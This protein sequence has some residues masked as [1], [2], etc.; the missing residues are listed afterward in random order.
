MFDRIKQIWRQWSRLKKGVV[1]FSTLFIFYT[2]IGFLVLPFIVKDQIQKKGTDVLARQVEVEDVFINPYLFRARL[3]GFKVHGK[4]NDQIVMSFASLSG[5]VHWLPL[6]FSQTLKFSTI[7]LQEPVFRL[8]RY[9]DGLLNISDFLE[10]KA[11]EKPAEEMT[12]ASKNF[13]NLAMSDVSVIDGAIFID[14]QLKSFTHKITA[15]NFGLPSIT[16]HKDKVEDVVTPHFSAIVNGTLFDFAGESKPFAGSHETGVDFTCK[17]MDLAVLNPYLPD[18]VPF[19]LS[20]GEL[21]FSLRAKS[22]YVP[23]EKRLDLSLHGDIRLH[24][25]LIDD[26][27]GVRVAAVSS[28]DISIDTADLFTQSLRLNSIKIAQPELYVERLKDGTMKFADFLATEEKEEPEP[29]SS[30]MLA[31]CEEISI[32]GGTLV[33]VDHVPAQVTTHTVSELDVTVQK[34]ST[35]PGSLF[36]FDLGLLGNE[37]GT[38]KLAGQV[39]IFPLQVQVE[40]ELGKF[41]LASGQNYIAEQAVVVLTEGTASS[42]FAVTG[43]MVEQGLDFQLTADMRIDDLVV[44]AGKGKSEVVGLKSFQTGVVVKNNPFSLKVKNVDLDNPRAYVELQKNGALNMA[45]LM[46][47]KQDV[48]EPAEPVAHESASILGKDGKVELGLL[49]IRNGELFVKDRSIA[50]FYH[51]DITD[52][53]GTVTDVSTLVVEGG[54]FTFK[55]LFDHHS[56]FVMA[57]HANP[58]PPNQLLDVDMNFVDIEMSPFSPYSQKFIGRDLVKGKLSLKQ[59]IKVQ[60][61]ALNVDTNIYLDQLGL[62]TYK[63]NDT[64]TGLPVGLAVALLQDRHG[65][66]SFDVPIEGSLDDPEFGVGGAVVSVLVNLVTKAAMSPFSLLGSMFSGDG[67][68]QFVTFAPETVSVDAK[69][70]EILISFAKVLYDRPGLKVEIASQYD[71]VSEQS[72]VLQSKFMNILQSEKLQDVKDAASGSLDIVIGTEEFGI[73]L[74][75]AYKTAEFKRP[76]NMVGILEKQTPAEMERMLKA[77]IEVTP[78]ELRLLAMQRGEAV[79]ALLR[80]HGPVESERLFVLEPTLLKIG[81][82]QVE[83]RLQ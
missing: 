52:I 27:Q 31:E 82:P 79:A 61:K 4:N 73:Y 35:V 70:Q 19:V 72:T 77:N 11:E 8:T 36:D 71:A 38:L 3:S 22:L 1:V 48:A 2:V 29:S 25:V 14:D 32:V 39:G 68:S 16:D 23:E 34:F 55:A 75:A 49:T 51:V 20:K 30:S 81:S 74:L 58:F 6:L 64:A 9:P 78:G 5:R 13:L 54:A 45:S 66:I 33:L 15:I 53:N 10:R 47:E 40:G 65:V 18:S 80:E 12:S 43:E 76:R 60:N 56:P 57:G 37:S 63:A 69:Q 50:P 67:D 7:Q 26:R 41:P 62:G 83:L 17:N 59:Q 44:L 24:D 21:D 42:T 46:K 28:V